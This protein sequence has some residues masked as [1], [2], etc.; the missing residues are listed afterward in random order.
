MTAYTSLRRQQV[1][2]EVEGDLS[3]ALQ[4]TTAE[5]CTDSYHP[6]NGIP[7]RELRAATARRCYWWNVQFCFNNGFEHADESH[8]RR[9]V[10][11]KQQ[12]AFEKHLFLLKSTRCIPFGWTSHLGG[13]D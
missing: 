5:A 1:S 4:Q 6:R 11:R 13:L 12:L 2:G 10:L 8:Q 3:N 7:A 9:S